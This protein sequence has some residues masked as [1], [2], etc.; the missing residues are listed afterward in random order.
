V[1]GMIRALAAAAC[2][3]GAACS[4]GSS[5]ADARQ[6]PP[7]AA[8]AESFAAFWQPFRTALLAGDA[9]QVATRTRLPLEERGILPDE[10]AR[11]VARAELDSA[12][13]RVLAQ[14]SGMGRRTILTNRD[15][16]AQTADVSRAA[17]GLQVIGDSARLGGLEFAR[18]RRR[19]RLIRIYIAED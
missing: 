7:V 13:K 8:V 1:A 9:G 6:A 5:S 4:V 15:L 19:W 18:E 12:L 14:D 17:P 10:P 16:V 11:R 3:L 2:L